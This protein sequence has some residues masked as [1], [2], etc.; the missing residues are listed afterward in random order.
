MNAFKKFVVDFIRRTDHALLLACIGCS[1][2]GVFLLQGIHL[3][4][5]VQ[6]RSVIVQVIATCL[7]VGVACFISL[8]DYRDLAR[9]W[10]LY[11]PVAVFFV[12]LTYFIGMRR[13]G[14]E[15][16]DDKAWL[17]IPFVGLT[18]QPSEILKLALILSLALHL[19]RIGEQINDPRNLF[20]LALHGGS[21]T[22][23]VLLQGDAGTAMVFVVIFAAMLFAA[24][25]DVRLIGAALA[26]LAVVAPLAWFFVLDDDKRFRFLVIFNPALDP[27]GKGWQQNLSMTAIGSGQI[28]GKGV[29]TGEAQ[30]VP[31]MYNDFIFSFI[32]ESLGFLGCLAVMAVILVLCILILRSAWRAK[33]LLGRYICVGVFA[34]IAFQMIWGIGMAVSLLPV[35]GLPMPFLS[36]GGTSVVM[37]YAAI[38]LVLCVHRGSH[39]SI[40]E[41]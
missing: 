23:L 26:S 24:G 32:G 31:E 27:K 19:E 30:Y 17:E 21:M 15:Y 12:V 39:S 6:E 41:R 8:F 33:D 9:L 1:A 28:S 4:G 10:K 38:G 14:Y 22:V 18:F 11:V 20:Y 40:F 29:M 25:L 16:I 37:T 3:S 7:G 35:A 34:L 13:A 2:F 36:A 5:H